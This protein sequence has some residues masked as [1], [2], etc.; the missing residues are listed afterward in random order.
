MMIV[1]FNTKGVNDDGYFYG[2]ASVF[3]VVD[4]DG[5]ILVQGA[6]QESLQAW[7]KKAE[8]PAML[9]QHAPDVTLGTWQA[10]SEDAYGLVVKGQLDLTLPAARHVQQLVRSG[11]V[12]GLSIGFHPLNAVFHNG[13]RYIHRVDLREISIVTEACNRMACITPF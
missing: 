1:P 7:E 13:Y 2:Y 5:D 10:M 12:K 8:K 11:D 4:H 9:W 3:H 6:F